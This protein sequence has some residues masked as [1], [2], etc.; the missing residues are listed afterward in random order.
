LE[1]NIELLKKVNALVMDLDGNIKAVAAQGAEAAKFNGELLEGSER[2]G[3]LV[4]A[5]IQSLVGI[6][7]AL[8]AGTKVIDDLAN[9]HKEVGPVIESIFVVARKTNMLA[10]NA[11]IEAARA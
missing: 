6:K 9:S 2:D 4:A 11:A 8:E 3:A 5:E 1:G 7:E 10:L